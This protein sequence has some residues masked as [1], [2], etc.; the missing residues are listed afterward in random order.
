MKSVF[1]A[2]SLAA[3]SANTNNQAVKV[4][5]SCVTTDSIENLVL[6]IPYPDERSAQLLTLDAGD[7]DASNYGGSLNW[8]NGIATVTIPIDACNMRGT[9]Y[10]TPS[11]SRSANYG[12]YKPTATV[13]FGKK[14]GD[15]PIIFRSLPI[16]AECGTRTSYTVNFDYS[17]IT[18][19]DTTGCEMV[20]NVCVFP[21][22]GDE[23]TFEIKEYTDD[24]FNVE[25][26]NSTRSYIAGKQIYLS[27]QVTGLAAEAK[28][29]VNQCKIVDGETEIVLLNPGAETDSSCKLDELAVSAA[30][31]N[32]VGN[33]VFNFQHILFLLKT[34]QSGISSFHLT[35]EIE[36][37]LKDDASS[38]CNSAAAVC[39]DDY[40][41]EDTT[42][43]ATE[44][45]SY[46]CDSFCEPDSECSI[47]N[48]VPTCKLKNAKCQTRQLGDE[49]FIFTNS[50]DSEVKCGWQLVRRVGTSASRWHP[51]TDNVAGT[52]VYGTFTDNFL[53]DSTFSRK[54]DD[55]VFDQFLFATG[56]FS[57]FL[58][59]TPDAVGRFNG[60]S[61]YDYDERDVIKSGSNNSPHQSY[62]TNRCSHSEDPWLSDPSVSRW[63]GSDWVY[64]ES[65]VNGFQSSY[66]GSN[67]GA[68]VFIRNSA[69]CS[70]VNSNSCEQV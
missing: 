13:V 55:I 53:S 32:S 61:C 45:Q 5:A 47:E 28:F 6:E 15:V 26:D 18:T 40:N 27:M 20:G 9:L 10:S 58:I 8:A 21:S 57:R 63:G 35:C 59:M 16:A 38:K 39:I 51:A 56:S 1:I 30:Y 37:C 31:D 46:M 24:N 17:N 69:L 62:M 50:T 25:V 33:Y 3:A 34:H 43:A 64:G 66:Q 52:D 2:A 11:V 14:L 42:L 70:N 67:L 60:G 49:R 41:G 68:N 4:G 7:C 36:V 29:A 12:L 23:A 65:S 54:Y 19:A 22:Y 48:D 44:K